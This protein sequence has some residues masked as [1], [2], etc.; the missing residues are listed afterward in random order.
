MRRMGKKQK[1]YILILI[2]L[3][4]RFLLLLLSYPFPHYIH[5]PT[6]PPRCQIQT[7]TIYLYLLCLFS[8]GTTLQ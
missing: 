3:L 4:I 7:K 1:H 5:I 8:P 6:I 2:P